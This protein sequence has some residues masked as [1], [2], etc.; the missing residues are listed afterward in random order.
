MS[1]VSVAVATTKQVTPV[2]ATA[3]RI[4]LR[5]AT[6]VKDSK[7]VVAPFD[8]TFTGVEDGHYTMVAQA[9]DASGAPVGERVVHE[10]DVASIA[11]GTNS[12]VQPV[13][14]DIPSTLTVTVTA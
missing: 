10:F 7:D 1:T 4:E 8:A 6:G 5:D 9:I 12:T 11:A 2:Q 13:E 3:I 14:S